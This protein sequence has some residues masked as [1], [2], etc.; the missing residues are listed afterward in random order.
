MIGIRVLLREGKE[1]E[2]H[3]LIVSCLRGEY[4]AK[5]ASSICFCR[6]RARFS[7]AKRFS[8]ALRLRE[9]RSG[10]F[11]RQCYVFPVL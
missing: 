5:S 6:S 9:P 10:E 8:N 11:N 4:D 3:P 2:I 7:G 1:H